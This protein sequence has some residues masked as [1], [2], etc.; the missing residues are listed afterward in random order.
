MGTLGVNVIIN[1]LSSDS[2]FTFMNYLEG[3]IKWSRG[4][5]VPHLCSIGLNAHRL[6]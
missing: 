2:E 6:K 1:Y 3:R 5:E 4:P